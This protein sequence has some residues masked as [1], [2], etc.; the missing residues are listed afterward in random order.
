MT[1]DERLFDERLFD[2]LLSERARRL[3]ISKEEA[4]RT[5]PDTPKYFESAKQRA[6][7]Q[8]K[9]PQEVLDDDLRRLREC[10]GTQV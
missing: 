8:G 7:E 2:E 3:G 5:L 4:L 1:E 6:Q 10:D 9:T